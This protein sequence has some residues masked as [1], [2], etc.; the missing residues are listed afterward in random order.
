MIKVFDG[1][2]M[3]K[4]RRDKRL[5]QQEIADYLEVNQSTIFKWES[6]LSLPNANQLQL[7]SQ[8]LDVDIDALFEKSETR[9][10]LVRKR[11]Q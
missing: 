6:G 5:S 9:S 11:N 10:S 4:I 8:I 3:I 2:K 1:N 7:I